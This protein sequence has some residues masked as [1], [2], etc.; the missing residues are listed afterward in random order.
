MSELIK[1]SRRSHHDM[2]AEF[3]LWLKLYKEGLSAYE[4]VEELGI[5]TAQY[6]SYLG[7]AIEEGYTAVVTPTYQTARVKDLPE[8]IRKMLHLEGA[9]LVKCAVAADGGVLLT[10][11]T[12]THGG[13]NR[14][15][16]G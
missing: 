6:H 10:P 9:T 1:R 11:L 15:E 13:N 5:T 16:Q 14:E 12:R 7:R 2:Q 4:I 3:E 8:E